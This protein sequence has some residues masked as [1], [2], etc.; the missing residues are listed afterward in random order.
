MRWYLLCRRSPVPEEVTGA[1]LICFHLILPDSRRMRLHFHVCVCTCLCVCSSSN[2]R[3]G[4]A[5]LWR[6]ASQVRPLDC[7]RGWLELLCWKGVISI[8]VKWSATLL[9]TSLAPTPCVHTQ[10]HRNTH[11]AFASL[12]PPFS[13]MKCPCA[14]YLKKKKKKAAY[15]YQ[16][17]RNRGEREKREALEDKRGG[18]ITITVEVEEILLDRT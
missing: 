17:H 9:L 4:E 10:T 8:L 12:F 11:P 16:H 14:H 13:L 15:T 18:T 6:E 2:S 5:L 1:E 3:S 7:G